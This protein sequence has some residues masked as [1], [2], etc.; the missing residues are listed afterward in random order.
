[1]I[2]VELARVKTAIAIC[3]YMRAS[4][5]AAIDIRSQWLSGY[6]HN[7]RKEAQKLEEAK[8]KCLD[9]HCAC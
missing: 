5:F 3:T 7:R 9:A 2:D 1:M 8:D 4:V 6:G